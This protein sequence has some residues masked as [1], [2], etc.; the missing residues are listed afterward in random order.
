[1][2]YNYY[3]KPNVMKNNVIYAFFCTALKGPLFLL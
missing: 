1:M 2:Y 3:I